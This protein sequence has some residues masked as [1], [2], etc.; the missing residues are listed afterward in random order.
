MSVFTI[1]TFQ[2]LSAD[3][4]EEL[5][6]EAKMQFYQAHALDLASCDVAL[7]DYVDAFIEGYYKH[8]IC[9]TSSS[10][11][12]LALDDAS[13]KP[14]SST[15]IG[16]HTLPT[17]EKTTEMSPEGLAKGRCHAHGIV[18]FAT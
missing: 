18:N 15:A 6:H 13:T 8:Q 11:V 14:K 2:L 10:S 17:P 7:E 9:T 12:S 5:G 16:R 3:K 4:L 1:S